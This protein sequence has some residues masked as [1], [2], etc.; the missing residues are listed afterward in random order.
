[1]AWEVPWC[2]IYNEKWQFRC[3][4]VALCCPGQASSAQ[5]VPGRSLQAFC[6]PNSPVWRGPSSQKPGGGRERWSPC[7]CCS[8]SPPLALWGSLLSSG[9]LLLTVTS[10]QRQCLVCSHLSLMLLR[11]NHIQTTLS[12]VEISPSICIQNTKQNLPSY[13]K[14]LG[15]ILKLDKKPSQNTHF[16]HWLWTRLPVSGYLHCLPSL[17]EKL[18]KTWRQEE[19][20]AKHTLCRRWQTLL[21]NITKNVQQKL[22]FIGSRI[23]A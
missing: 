20:F 2:F 18:D 5:A 4:C 3:G 8:L 1:M 16:A 14:C 22:I 9:I 21:E 10:H 7:W 17:S 19:I 15:Q 11:T 6:R 12:D 23:L 13:T